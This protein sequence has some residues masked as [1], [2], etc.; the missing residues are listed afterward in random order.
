MT[1][2]SVCG[3]NIIDPI[4]FAIDV[5]QATEAMMG[6]HK[7]AVEIITITNA[8]GTRPGVGGT[9]VRTDYRVS[10][11]PVDFFASDD[12][13]LNPSFQQVSGRDIVLSG[14]LLTNKDFKL[15]PIVYPYDTSFYTG[16]IDIKLTNPDMQS[17]NLQLYFKVTG[18]GV[19]SS[20]WYFKRIW[21]QEDSNLSYYVYIR[22]TAEIP[23]P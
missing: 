20:G 18:E 4:R 5:T 12:G 2:E 17:N 1:C 23:A 19:P 22:N 11:G 3:L 9:R 13:Y 8:G 15:G 16:G 10:I 7:F 21:G 14:N 6:L